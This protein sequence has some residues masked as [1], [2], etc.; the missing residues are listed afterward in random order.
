MLA[1]LRAGRDPAG[2]MRTTAPI[3]TQI[4]TGTLET[5]DNQIDPTTGT[6]RLKAIFD[7]EN[8]VLFPNQFVN[9][10]LLLDTKRES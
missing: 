10:R 2:R 6:S 1:K 4:A 7:N 3:A 9:C 5:V 8:R